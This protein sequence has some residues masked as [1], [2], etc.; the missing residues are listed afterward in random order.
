LSATRPLTPE[1][2][3]PDDLTVRTTNRHMNSVAAYLNRAENYLKSPAR[4]GMLVQ[5]D[6]LPARALRMIL[7]GRETPAMAIAYPLAIRAAVL[8]VSLWAGLLPTPATA[9]EIVHFRS[10]DDNGPGQ[11]TTELEGRLFRP[12]GAGPFSAVVGLPGCSGM[13][14]R[15]TNELTPLYHSWGDELSRRGYVVL[16]VDSLGP[17]GHGEMCSITG[18]D[19]ILYRKRPHDAYGALSYLQQQPFVRGDR[20]GLIGWSQGGGV[21]LSVIGSQHIGRPA[22]P[23]RE[24]RAAI[25][26]YPGACN[27][28]RHPADWTANVPLLVLIGSADVWTPLAPCQAFL[29][30]AVARGSAINLVAYP[31][32]YHGFDAP[33][34][35]RRELPD[36]RTRAGVVPIVG[37]DPAARADALVRVPAFLDQYLGN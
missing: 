4:W 18:F 8:L 7:R 14:R 12:P 10:A 28:Q 35:P 26:F 24:F 2:G 3:L 5:T 29:S 31:E 13:M 9:Q 11:P 21:T 37:T 20:I 19:P 23:V 22:L 6:S 1:V 30:S 36:Y 33:N 17:R 25:A 15:N 32:A 34:N 16:L 27:E